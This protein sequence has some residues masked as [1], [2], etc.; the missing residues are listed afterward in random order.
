MSGISS[1][2]AGSVTNKNKYNSKE[3]QSQEFSDG[4]G[5]DWYDYGARMYDAQ[6]GRWHVIDPKAD[7]DRRWTPYRY[8]YDN[9]LRY[10]DP[11]GMSEGDFY[12]EK[13]EWLGSD[14]INDNKVYL[15]TDSKTPIMPIRQNDPSG[16]P[17]L[18]LSIF[19]DV[20]LVTKGKEEF[21]K[22]QGIEKRTARLE[23][24]NQSLGAEIQASTDKITQN[25]G[26]I[27]ELEKQAYANHEKNKPLDGDPKGGMTIVTIKEN[28]PLWKEEKKLQKENKKLQAQSNANQ[29]KINLNKSELNSLKTELFKK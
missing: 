18:S 26:R 12:N 1:K 14:G 16:Q 11:D 13:K 2:A 10:I 17:P 9:P 21:N 6:I 3:L 7:I 4:S 23:N 22:Q 20:T 27:N 15:V 28:I 24:E 29:Q 19:Q 8:A 25:K 5:L